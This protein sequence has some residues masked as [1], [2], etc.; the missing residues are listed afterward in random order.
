MDHYNPEIAPAPEEWLALD[1]GERVLLIEQYHR[2]A[3]ISLPK[4]AR[5]LHATIHA[6][7]ENQLS[8]EDQTIVR[9]TMDRLLKDGLTRHEAVHA[10]GSVLAG[11]I[12]DVLHMEDATDNAHAPY[13]SAL[14][15][16]TVEKWRDG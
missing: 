10:I 3:R 5:R 2:D 4:S 16:L 12:H 9:S 8:L 14:E 1:E 13:Y 15:Q 7:V 6:I 11:Y